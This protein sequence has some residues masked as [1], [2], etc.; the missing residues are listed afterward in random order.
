MFSFFKEKKFKKELESV[1]LTK[2]FDLQFSENYQLD[3]KQ[4]SRFAIN[5]YI[6]SAHSYEKRQSMYFK[7]TNTPEQV[8]AIIYYSEGHNK[9]VLE[10]QVYTTNCPLKITKEEDKWKISFN[11]YL[12][13]NNK[14]NAK[15]TFSAKF[16]SE[17][18]V[19]ER[20]TNIKFN[21][22]FHAFKKQK[23][24]Q[25]KIKELQKD[26]KITYDQ[27][28]KLKGR[29]ILEGQNV[30]IDVSCIRCHMFGNYDYSEKNNHVDLIIA[31][32]DTQV[33]FHVISEHNMPL[34]EVG[35]YRKNKST[36]N[37]IDSVIYERQLIN[38][39]LAPS[40]LNVLLKLDNE[41]EIALHIKKIDELELVIQEQYDIIIAIVEVL[42]EGKKYRGVME[43][44]FNQDKN[45][46]FDGNDISKL[47]K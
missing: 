24:Y 34:L 21:N 23:N 15:F 46:W 2:E 5:S 26:K 4:N 11:G 41:K 29:L 40:N 30:I 20:N 45:K 32:N 13:K 35:N 12:K 18:E 44:G 31:D 28:G 25:E 3:P 7:L 19:L 22:L 1:N 16:E 39:G 8:E 10:Q 36:I 9:Y 38:R 6:F 17:N 14:D 47:L 42:M 33:N 37:F 43:C 27:L